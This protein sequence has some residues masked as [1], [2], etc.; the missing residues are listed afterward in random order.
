MDKLWCLLSMEKTTCFGLYRPSSGLDNFLAKRILYNMP[1][2]RGDVEIS[3]YSSHFQVLTTF[4]LK[5]FCIICLNRVVML[6]SQH[7]HA[8]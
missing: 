6:R 2:P 3:A 5:E 4:L 8:V 1:K 7:R